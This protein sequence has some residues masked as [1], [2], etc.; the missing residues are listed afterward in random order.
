M[1]KGGRV[2]VFGM[3]IDTHLASVQDEAII[4]SIKV[5][6]HKTEDF[7]MEVNEDTKKLH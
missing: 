4:Q 1:E 6:V 3:M 2:Y 5:K 7:D